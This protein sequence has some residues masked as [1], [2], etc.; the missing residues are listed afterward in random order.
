MVL[1]GSCF[2]ENIGALLQENKFDTHLNPFG[3]LFN[4]FSLMN[5]LERMLNE[6][7]YT[8]GEMIQSGEQ[9]ASLDHHGRFNHR[10]PE[11]ALALINRA[12]YE[13]A[14]ALRR[15]DVIFIT[16][17]SAWVYRHLERDRLVGN[18]HKLP[19]KEFEKR[20]LSFQETHLILRHIPEFLRA[21]EIK[22]QVVFTISPV[23]HWKDGAME[24]QRSKAILLA[25]AHQVADEFATAH[26]FPAYE[27]MMDDLRDYRFYASDMLHPSEQ[28]LEYIWQ[29]FQESFFKEE[30]K[31]L[32]A[33]LKQVIQAAAH[34]PVDPESNSFQRFVRKQLEAIGE[35]ESEYPSL[36][37][38]KEKQRF[39]Q[40]RL[41]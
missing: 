33:K 28:A 20:L 31:T 21:M 11:E 35:L 26:Y 27:L 6:R 5:A 25:A 18:C 24:N 9:W 22:S 40:Y 34:R 14:A 29:K 2:A 37:L 30:T 4:P 10:D 7:P 3:I 8:P 17:G 13:G 39:Q 16:L 15:A 32:C 41:E 38:Q 23:R 1:L 36:D 19:N 12:L